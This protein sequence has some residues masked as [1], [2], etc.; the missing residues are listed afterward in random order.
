[1]TSEGSEESF[2]FMRAHSIATHIRD[3]VRDKKNYTFHPRKNKMSSSNDIIYAHEISEEI[4]EMGS[5]ML[6][7]INDL[8]LL[9]KKIERDNN[10]SDNLS[11]K[12][13]RSVIGPME[14]LLYREHRWLG[15]VAF[16]VERLIDELGEMKEEHEAFV[17]ENR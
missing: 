6:D 8:Y 11:D 10:Y 2:N 17:V 4:H 9:V 7:K 12:I 3:I 16:C 5:E 1:M 13:Y 14:M 15:G